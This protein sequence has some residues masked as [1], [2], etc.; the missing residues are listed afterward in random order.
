[1]KPFTVVDK[2][3]LQ[4]DVLRKTGK[5]FLESAKK[6]V[7]KFSALEEKY[8]FI[9]KT[10]DRFN[11]KYLVR[12][13]KRIV[14]SYIKKFTG[15]R[16]AQLYRL[17]AWAILGKPKRKEYVRC[18]LNKFYT[19]RDIK[20]LEETDEYHRRLSA[21]A[22]KEILRREYE[23]FRRNRYEN[24]SKISSSHINNLRN[25]V[26]CKSNRFNPTKVRRVGIG[27]AQPP[28]NNDIPGS[29]RVDSVHQRSVFHINCVDEIT[30]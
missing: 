2:I 12:K 6:L 18:N 11:Y 26:S 25:S 5:R 24:I 13:D 9:D 4:G 1:M 19:A 27:K 7:I 21:I 29:I 16:K 30:Q 15:Y 22:T 28:E 14:L 8:A 23:V 10:V 3:W 17:I 20:L